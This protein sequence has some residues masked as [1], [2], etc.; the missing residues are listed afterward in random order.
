MATPWRWRRSKFSSGSDEF[1]VLLCL[2]GERGGG[3]LTNS[4]RSEFKMP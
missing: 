3:G 1:F 2:F 4:A